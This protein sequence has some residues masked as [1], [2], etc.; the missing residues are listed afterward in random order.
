MDLRDATLA[1]TGATG[2]LGSH[3]AI[4]LAKAGA[5]VIGV[6]RTP[7]RGQWLT[8]AHGVE[9]IAADLTD[10][11]SLTKA[12]AGVDAVISNAALAGRGKH[13]DDYYRANV[14]G[15]EN[16]LNATAAADVSRMVAVSTVGIYQT[17]L[18]GPNNEDTPMIEGQ[19]RA[20]SQMFTDW[21]YSATKAE[22]ERR[23]WQLAEAHD[24][25]LTTI[26]PGPIYGERDDK[27]T[28]RYARAMN[29]RIVFAPTLK[30][31]HVHAGDVAIAIRS[32]LER[33]HSVGRAYNIVGDN[34]S[35]HR[36]ARTWR[37][38]AG[39]GP[40]I[41]PLPVPLAARFDDSRARRELDFKPRSLADGLRGC[42]GMEDEL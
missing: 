8:D 1:V 31:P 18:R 42:V 37:G 40:V 16:V 38:L 29:R 5:R 4:E 21:R 33:P 2:F 35:P 28:T 10:P 22:A 26:R 3:I 25:G 32:A 14:T 24:I 13:Y 23:A 36:V 39:R 15:T 7:S 11:A 6:V 9:F 19:S 17:Q 12:F 30:L 20:I 41:V 34:Y 27:L